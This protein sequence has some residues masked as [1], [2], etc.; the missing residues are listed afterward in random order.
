M[1]LPRYDTYRWTLLAG[2]LPVCLLGLTGNTVSL[3]SWRAN[4]K[5]NAV[6]TLFQALGLVDNVFLL[7]FIVRCARIYRRF[8]TPAL[9][10]VL[11]FLQ[12]V[13]IHLTLTIGV[14]RWLA[15]TRPLLMQRIRP[16]QVMLVCGGVVAWCAVVI[17]VMVG[18]EEAADLNRRGSLVNEVVY[19]VLALVLPTVALVGF[20]VSLLRVTFR[21]QRQQPRTKRRMTI[22]VLS[23]S[24]CS[25][26]ASAMEVASRVVIEFSPLHK[27]RESCD[28]PCVFITFSV[29]DFMHALNSS[30]NFFFYFFIA[31]QFR[32]LVRKAFS[33][34]L[35]TRDTPGRKVSTTSSF[36]CG[37]LKVTSDSG[38]DDDTCSSRICQR[39]HHGEDSTAEQVTLESVEFMDLPPPHREGPVA[40]A[41]AAAVAVVAQ[42]LPSSSADAEQSV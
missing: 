17:A 33:C 39:G 36:G 3:W 29:N 13:S 9:E 19:V 7:L 32:P 26:L 15:V 8:A 40:A 27:D 11:C 42:E 10:I 20:S 34:C 5:P 38:I 21:L 30:V 12:S 4:Q 16:R 22:A 14:F 2:V 24:V 6:I 25:L 35:Q 23:I 28:W 37:S 1:S 41:A 18:V 31:S